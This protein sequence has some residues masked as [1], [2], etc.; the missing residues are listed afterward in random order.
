MDRQHA[1]AG[2]PVWRVETE[3]AGSPEVP[4]LALA[5]GRVLAVH[6]LGGMVGIDEADG[7]VRWQ[8]KA[9]AA[10]VRGGPAGPGPGGRCALPLDDGRLLLAGPDRPQEVLDPPGR[11]S[12]VAV[13][14][15]E[16]LLVATRGAEVNALVALHGW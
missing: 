12:G 16:R 13:A 2:Q 4:P 14:A 3:G 6:R 8:A 15:G 9:D 1:A 5:D 7:R 10:A 11:V